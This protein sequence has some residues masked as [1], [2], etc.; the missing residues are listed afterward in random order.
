MKQNSKD[1]VHIVI[2]RARV[3]EFMAHGFMP[4]GVGSLWCEGLMD[5]SALATINL[6]YMVE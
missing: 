6:P 1:L 4:T 2:N 5:R 3:W